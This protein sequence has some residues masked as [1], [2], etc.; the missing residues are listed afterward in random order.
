MSSIPGAMCQLAWL[1]YR[2]YIKIHEDV[3]EGIEG[4]PIA[5]QILS[6]I[7]FAMNGGGW[8]WWRLFPYIDIQLFMKPKWMLIESQSH[9]ELSDVRP[10]KGRWCES[11]C[12]HGN[13]QWCCLFVYAAI[14]QLVMWSCCSFKAMFFLFGQIAM[15]LEN[16]TAS[17]PKGTFCGWTWF[18]YS[19][20]FLK[21]HAHNHVAPSLSTDLN[22][23]TKNIP[24]TLLVYQNEND[25]FIAMETFTGIQ[26]GLIFVSLLNFHA[27]S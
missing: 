20:G 12:A 14:A 5:L 2:G 11:S 25:V 9:H 23:K 3:Q 26:E 1:H 21:S 19:S 7:L 24:P 18:Q 8:R 13:T 17:S 10:V 27:T 4:F 6:W 15:T 16:M 22:K